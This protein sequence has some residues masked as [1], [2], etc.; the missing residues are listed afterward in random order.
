SSGTPEHLICDLAHSWNADVIVLGSRG[1]RGLRELF[2][3]S[4]SNYVT[5]HAPCSVWVVRPDRSARSQP[6]ARQS[7]QTEAQVTPSVSR[8]A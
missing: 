3:G 7:G 5:H 2:L 4:I 1:H 8:S 6:S